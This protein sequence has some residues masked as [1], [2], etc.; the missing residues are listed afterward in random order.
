MM[1]SQ[2]SQTVS[3]AGLSALAQTTQPA[4]PYSRDRGLY[5]SINYAQ[6]HSA[7]HYSYLELLVGDG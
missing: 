7:Q 3:A 5:C 1:I 6:H 4:Q 2:I